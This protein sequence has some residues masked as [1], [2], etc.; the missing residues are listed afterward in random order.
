MTIYKSLGVQTTLHTPTRRAL[1]GVDDDGDDDDGDDDGRGVSGRD[2]RRTLRRAGAPRLGGG[3]RRRL[4][5][6]VRWSDSPRRKRRFESSCDTQ[7][8]R[9]TTTRWNGGDGGVDWKRTTRVRWV[10]SRVRGARARRDEGWVDVRTDEREGRRGRTTRAGRDAAGARGTVTRGWWRRVFDRGDGR[11]W[12]RCETSVGVQF[13]V[14]RGKGDAFALSGA[15]ARRAE[16]RVGKRFA[17][18]G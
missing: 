11:G 10:V 9:A 4:E 14:Y 7:R 16:R 15:A 3:R 1:N 8:R 2:A 18:V 6:W 12:R 17:S 5:S 13:V